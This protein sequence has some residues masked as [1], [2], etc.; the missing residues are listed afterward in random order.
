[1]KKQSPNPIGGQ[2]TAHKATGPKTRQGK[3]RSK[4]N[5][6]KHGLFFKDVLLPGESRSAYRS[7]LDGL[8][9]YWHPVGTQESVEVEKLAVVTWRQR[10]Y[11][12]VETTMITAQVE[13]AETDSAERQR[14]EALELSRAATA[15]GGLLMHCN[16]RFVIPE[17]IAMLGL[18]RV[19]VNKWGFQENCRL[20]VKL[21]GEDQDGGIP[22]NLR[23]MYEGFV[24]YTKLSEK[25]GDPSLDSK[26]RKIMIEH[27]D[28]HIER[29]TKHVPILAAADEERDFVKACA[30]LIP[31]QEISDRL[32][33]YETHLD[34]Q[35]DR[36]VKRLELL[37]R[38]RKRKR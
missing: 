24:T 8:R 10:R 36:I 25:Q 29:L 1:M 34:R 11:Y 2:P 27:I 38:M 33:R 4:L 35:I 7:L 20:I 17:V 13:F 32:M 14:M 26:Q 15:S 31:A 30:G 16:N 22:N 37:Q 12:A 28:A 9:D 19:I 18:L 3:Q 21:C 5:A 6:L 23:M